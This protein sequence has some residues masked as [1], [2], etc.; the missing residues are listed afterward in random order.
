VRL[1][2]PPV[3]RELTKD[4]QSGGGIWEVG[5]TAFLSSQRPPL[6]SPL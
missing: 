1:I 2:L 5:E 4:R 6:F 3:D